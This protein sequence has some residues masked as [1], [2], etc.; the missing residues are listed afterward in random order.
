MEPVPARCA[1][2]CR[3]YQFS[4]GA[5]VGDWPY[6]CFGALLIRGRRWAVGDGDDRK[7]PRLEV[8]NENLYARSRDQTKVEAQRALSEFAAIAR[9]IAGSNPET[10]NLMRR[11]T[12]LI[13]Q[14]DPK[15]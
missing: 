3:R 15:A 5:P 7:P 6:G 11:L 2:R 4:K 10:I 8:V 9:V 14:S 13:R 1:R 12:P